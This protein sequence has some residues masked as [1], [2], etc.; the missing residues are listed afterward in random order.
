MRAAIAFALLAASTPDFQI[1]GDAREF[2]P[3]IIST[4]YSDVRLT[5]SPDGNTL[6]VL[7][8]SVAAL[9]ADTRRQFD[10]VYE[11]ILGL[12]VAPMRRQ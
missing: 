3:D 5:I 2:A 1:S 7:K 12:M 4:K 11:A 6:D 9:D 8:R 10:Q